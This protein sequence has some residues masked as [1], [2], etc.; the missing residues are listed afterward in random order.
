MHGGYIKK[1]NKS[2]TDD[3]Y[4]SILAHLQVVPLQF[5]LR[6]KRSWWCDVYVSSVLLSPSL[7]FRSVLFGSALLLIL[8]NTPHHK[9]LNIWFT[10]I[11]VE[12]GVPD[13]KTDADADDGLMCLWLLNMY[14]TLLNTQIE[15][16]TSLQYIRQIVLN[17]SY[18]ISH[19]YT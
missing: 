14:E 15:H 12:Y 9:Y 11:L 4:I 7:R 18:T 19:M 8:P 10:L 1:R 16:Q 5:T 6:R 3:V 17:C 2:W 13:Y